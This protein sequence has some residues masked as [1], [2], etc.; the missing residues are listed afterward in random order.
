MGIFWQFAILRR[1]ECSM[2]LSVVFFCLVLCCSF[3]L[4]LKTKG[5]KTEASLFIT[6]SAKRWCNGFCTLRNLGKIWPDFAR[7]ESVKKVLR[8]H[9]NYAWTLSWKEWLNLNAC[10]RDAPHQSI[11]CNLITF[12][13]A[14][15]PEDMKRTV[16]SLVAFILVKKK[17]QAEV[18]W[19][20]NGTGI[21]SVPFRGKPLLN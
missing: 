4:L 6:Q 10:L 13:G 20:V 8:S 17:R 19:Y 3:V 16:N 15:L 2:S 18:C 5:F 21:S 1:I 11:Q 9:K 14:C 12:C 7:G